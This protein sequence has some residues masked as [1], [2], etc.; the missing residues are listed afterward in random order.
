MR[1]DNQEEAEEF[2]DSQHFEY[3]LVGVVIHMGIADAG[4][5]MSYINVDR[6]QDSKEN[7]Q[8]WLKTE[9][10]RWLEFNDTSVRQF[11]FSQLAYKCFGESKDR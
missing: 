5:Y 1:Q 7:T 3:K 6:T 10:Q 9:N 2:S 11:D 8:E 4:H